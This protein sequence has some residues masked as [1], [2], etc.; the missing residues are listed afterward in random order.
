[1][2]PPTDDEVAER[3]AVLVPHVR[4]AA[5]AWF[6]LTDSVPITQELIASLQCEVDAALASHRERDPHPLDGRIRFVVNREGDT[7]AIAP[8]YFPPITRLTL[9]CRV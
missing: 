9:T 1:M 8:R 3:V 2:N 5:Q 7:L 4:A 6:D